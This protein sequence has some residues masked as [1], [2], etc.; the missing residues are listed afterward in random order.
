[1]TTLTT[2]DLVLRP[3]HDGDAAALVEIHRDPAMRR[4]LTRPVTTPEEATKWWCR[5]RRA[6]PRTPGTASPSSTTTGSPA[7][8]C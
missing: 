2:A 6:G 3:W 7:A 4:W 8:W 1:M 5:S